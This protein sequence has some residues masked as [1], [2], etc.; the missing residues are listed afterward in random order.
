MKV[1]IDLGG[2]KIEGIVL[3]KDGI[4]LSRKRIPSPG[5]DYYGILDSIRDLVSQLCRLHAI[6]EDVPVGIGIP[7]ALSAKTGLIKNANT[8][9][10]IGKALDKDLS[11]LLCRPVK[12]TNDAN[13][14]T[15]S[16]AIDGAG[17]NYNF[18]FGVILG[19]GVGGGLA[20]QKK[21]IVG[22]NAITGEWGH[23][24]LP[25]LT[26]NKKFNYES[27]EDKIRC[28]CGKYNCIETFLSGP[29]LARDFMETFNYA[30]EA[31][32]I[33]KSAHNGNQEAKQIINRYEHR[34]ARALA[35]VINVLDP[36]VIILG[37]GLSNI[38]SLYKNVPK[39]WQ[40][41]VFSDHCSTKLLQNYHGDS[42]G[43]RGAAWL[44]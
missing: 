11:S 42:S 4:T 24:P 29:A 26:D 27:T 6:H 38:E 19:T 41:W 22:A 3:S 17:K 8:T 39:L 12:L 25:W 35:S 44:W 5:N 28:Y 23:N 9:C 18:V 40:H 32:D 20:F 36:E 34:L 30:L 31:R 33:V 37:G 7:G 16:E 1:G 2:T 14:F 15:I 13:C 10:L 43:V 21:I